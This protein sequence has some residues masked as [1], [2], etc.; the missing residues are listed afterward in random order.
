ME[1]TSLFQVVEMATDYTIA[2]EGFAE[3]HE[4]EIS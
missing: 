2:L 3:M 1:F 4:E